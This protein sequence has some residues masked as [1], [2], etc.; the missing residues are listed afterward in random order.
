VSNAP[1]PP[2]LGQ[3]LAD[4]KDPEKPLVLDF[5]GMSADEFVAAVDAL[6]KAAPPVSRARCGCGAD[7]VAEGADEGLHE[8]PPTV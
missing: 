3:F 8:A 6:T 5:S 1:K 7:H 4:L 2:T